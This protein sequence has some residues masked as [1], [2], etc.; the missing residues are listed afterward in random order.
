MKV[1]G[2]EILYN[3]YFQVYLLLLS[4]DHGFLSEEDPPLFHK[5]FTIYRLS[6][7]NLRSQNNGFKSPSKSN[8]ERIT[9]V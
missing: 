7:T 2:H 6:I 9:K 8:I 1:A 3:H 5:S 4:L